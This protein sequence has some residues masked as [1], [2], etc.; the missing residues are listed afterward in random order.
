MTPLEKFRNMSQ[1]EFAMFGMEHVAYLKQV[2]AGTKAGCAV[3]AA[4]GTQVALMPDRAD[5]IALL[6]Q[7]DLYPVSV[8]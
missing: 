2:S 5:A 4:D 1:N 3:F 8:H 6:Q 7:N